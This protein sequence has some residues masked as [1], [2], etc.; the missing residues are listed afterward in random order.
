MPAPAHRDPPT[1]LRSLS[2]AA[3]KTKTHIRRAR[4]MF[5]FHRMV[6]RCVLDIGA[7]FSHI[8]LR[9]DFAFHVAPPACAEDD[10]F[11]GTQRACAP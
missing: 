2:D 3:E 7:L 11:R 5:G 4:N 1:N 9:A 6:G 10:R 8:S